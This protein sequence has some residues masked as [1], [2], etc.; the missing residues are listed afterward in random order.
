MVKAEQELQFQV[1]VTGGLI[2]MDSECTLPANC[3]PHCANGQPPTWCRMLCSWVSRSLPYLQVGKGICP[4][5]R[6]I[7]KQHI[8]DRIISCVDDDLAMIYAG[9]ATLIFETELVKID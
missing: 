6:L 7:A 3:R 5:A 8:C 4:E 2:A 9:G 1:S